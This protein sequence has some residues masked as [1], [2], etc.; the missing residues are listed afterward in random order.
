MIFNKKYDIIS[1]DLINKGEYIMFKESLMP[2]GGAEIMGAYS[3]E[4][5]QLEINI[6]LI[7]NQ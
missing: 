2:E 6:L 4:Y 7:A 5:L 3:H 1:A